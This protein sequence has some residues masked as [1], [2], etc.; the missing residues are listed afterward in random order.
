LT[1]IALASGTV[2]GGTEPIIAAVIADT[3]RFTSGLVQ[4]LNF[5]LRVG[6]SVLIIAV[7]AF[8]IRKLAGQRA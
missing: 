1:R 8:V 4:S 2:A 5:L 3:I 7:F 6:I